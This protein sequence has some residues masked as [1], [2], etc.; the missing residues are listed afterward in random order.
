[1]IVNFDASLSYDPANQ[2]ITEDNFSWDVANGATDD[3]VTCFQEDLTQAA[4]SCVFKRPGV[5]LPK[6]T[7]K[8]SDSENI[9]SGVAYQTISVAA[10]KA[11]IQL[12]AVTGGVD[13]ILREYDENGNLL[14]DINEYSVTLE[15]AKAGIKF[16]ASGTDTESGSDGRRI[17]KYQWIFN[18][19]GLSVTGSGNSSGRPSSG[20]LAISDTGTTISENAKSITRKFNKRGT[21]SAQL[22]VTDTQG[23]I[24]RKLFTIRVT[25]LVA[26]MTIANDKSTGTPGE[27]FKFDASASRS[28]VSPNLAY[29]WKIEDEGPGGLDNFEQTSF[30]SENETFDYKFKAP[31]KKKVT[32]EVQV[33][34]GGGGKTD[35]FTQVI[36][37]NSQKPS[38]LFDVTFP[39][40]TNRPSLVLL[41]ASTSYDLDE[42]DT[43]K[44]SWR[45]FNATAGVDYEIISGAEAVNN[46]NI[47]TDNPKV[48]LIFKRKG[49]YK[50]ELVVQDQYEPSLRQSSTIN[51]DVV[52]NTVIDVK[53]ADTQ[54]YAAQLQSVDSG[55]LQSNF[56]FDIESQNAESVSVNFGD[57]ST[58]KV[59]RFNAGKAT[60]NHTYT[61]AGSYE[62]TLKASKANEINEAKALIIIGGGDKPV[63]IPRIKIGSSFVANIEDMPE[64]YRGTAISFDA[65]GSVNSDATSSNLSYSWNM[66]DGRAYST[67]IV[68]SHTYNDLPPA[69]PGFF[70]VRLT[71]TDN[72]DVTKSDTRIIPIKVVGA[73][74]EI[75]TIIA[76]VVGDQDTTPVNVNVEVVAPR[77]RDGT[78]TKYR[79][80]YFPISDQSREL[81]V[82]TST[83]PTA[84]LT[85]NT[86]GEAGA[87]VEYGIC[88][89]IED[90]DENEV[91]CKDLFEDGNFTTVKVTN[92]RNDPPTVDFRV[93]RTN[94]RV[95]ET[96]NFYDLSR[97]PDGRII[98]WAYD[99]DGDNS[100][101]NNPKFEQGNISHTFTKKSP[102]DGYN[103]RLRVTDDKGSSAVSQTRKIYVDGILEPP[104]AAFTYVTQDD[105]VLFTDKSK[106]DIANAGTIKSYKWD[107]NA[108]VD[109][110]GD[111]NLKND[112]DSIEKNPK[113]TYASSGIY[114]VNFT[115]EDSESNLATIARQVIVQ[116][117]SSDK[118]N[119]FAN[120]ESTISISETS[121][122]YRDIL[123]TVP[124]RDASTGVIRISEENPTIRFNFSHLP[125]TTSKIILDQNIYFDT[126]SGN[127]SLRNYGPGDGVRNN[128]IDVL[129][130][131][132]RSFDVRFNKEWAPIRIQIAV[133][134]ASGNIYTDQADVVFDNNEIE[135]ADLQAALKYNPVNNLPASIYFVIL[136][137]AS[138]LST[139]ILK[140][141]K[142]GPRTKI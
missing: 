11:K 65:S 62:V 25:D 14:V 12:K 91:K 3:A 102:R 117:I 141:N 107:F 135:A 50:V 100:F 124:A 13:S 118:A 49:T 75:Q 123:R 26:R 78:I 92:G 84:T 18:D 67:A 22:V 43:L 38:A 27:E 101:V 82:K 90:S 6:L 112:A 134:D 44:Y 73:K 116:K 47:F 111:G 139:F 64:I 129:S 120:A 28:D 61:R 105:E 32:V 106:I 79:Y 69:T 19:T 58:P 4:V 15:Q 122:L 128:D 119:P 80:Y 39:E 31:G 57:N 131:S 59:E 88:V 89:D 127:P 113:H 125:A 71:I 17:T 34:G 60:V 23:N 21:I 76:E 140:N 98:E 33:D 56:T 114:E 1:M 36:T 121:N 52:I 72:R 46:P 2:S 94:I 99:L 86:F 97:D 83:K 37:I 104:I 109:S 74:P 41:D 108:L 126:N 110:D 138:I 132:L 9:V 87:E 130:Q 136:F 35:S 40:K 48:E 137:A 30:S 103:I 5:Y 10:P 66:G 95:G 77:D 133:E 16:D 115:V 24:D 81:G 53:F 55:G 29:K 63:A 42:G 142:K 45:I 20:D 51:R 96:I 70:E 85:L 7:V 54:I 93:D 68:P 8:S